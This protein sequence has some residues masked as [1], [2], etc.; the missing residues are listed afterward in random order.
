MRTFEELLSQPIIRWISQ[1]RLR[2]ILGME[3]RQC[4]GFILGFLLTAGIGQGVLGGESL[5]NGEDLSG[6]RTVGSAEWRVEE[7]VLKGGQDGD[8]KRSGLIMTEAQFQ[9]FELSLEFKIDEHGKYNSGIYLRHGVGERRRRGYQVNIGRG[10]AEEYV[11]LYTDRWLDKGDE[12]D[13]YRKV[14]AWNQLRIRA[15]KNHIQVWLNG[16]LIV[17]HH[18]EAATQEM[19][20]PGVIALQTY[21]AE[22]HSGWVAFRNMQVTE[23]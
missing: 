13:E 2:I 11:G 9:D 14:L 7:G 8:P 12:R 10:V 16:H 21:G 3:T 15:I 20:Q 19:L 18:D 22:G 4:W 1:L 17:D 23:Y 6:W 5:L